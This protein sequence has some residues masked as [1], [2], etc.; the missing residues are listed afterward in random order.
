LPIVTD[1]LGT[2]RELFDESG[3][4]C[5]WRAD[6]S[7]WGKTRK[8][9]RSDV[10]V[11]TANCSIRF[12]GQYEDVESGL[13][14]NLNRYYDPRCG[15][16]LSPDPIGL[17]GGIRPNAYVHNPTTYIDPLGLAGCTL[18]KVDAADHDYVLSLD[19]KVYPQAFGHISDAIKAGHPS[20]VTIQ[21]SGAPK[22]RSESLRGIKPKPKYDRDEYPMAMMAE[23]GKGASVRYIDPKDNQGAGSSI[24]HA[25]RKY[26][27]QEIPDGTKIKIEVYD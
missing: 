18:K 22:N 14:Y 21:R 26:N 10:D 3:T 20:I 19:K 16:Y 7:L 11:E 2:P 6:T 25:L 23:G 17:A 8:F 5:L 9:V 1:H 15:M 27:N 4:T 13:Y 12:Q 24:G